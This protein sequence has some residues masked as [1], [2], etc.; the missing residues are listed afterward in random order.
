MGGTLLAPCT[1]GQTWAVLRMVGQVGSPRPLLPVAQ[2]LPKVGRGPLWASSQEGKADDHSPP[3]HLSQEREIKGNNLYQREQEK[4]FSHCWEG[5]AP[6]GS[7]PVSRESTCGP[8]LSLAKV[9]MVHASNTAPLAPRLPWQE[10]GALGVGLAGAKR[11]RWAC[12]YP[13]ASRVQTAQSCCGPGSQPQ[14]H[15][16]P[17]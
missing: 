17:G 2:L 11:R 14:Q 12:R 3:P 8:V 4:R 1:P 7:G 5:T 9:P 6:M 15:P 16:C 10:R 13:V